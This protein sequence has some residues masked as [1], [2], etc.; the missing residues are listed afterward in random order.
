MN[1]FS[2]SSKKEPMHMRL[3][4][5][6]WYLAKKIKGRM[7]GFSLDAS[8]HETTKAAINAGRLLEQ[9]EKGED[10]AK[11]K[12]K[13]SK[14]VPKYW[15]EFENRIQKWRTD[16]IRVRNEAII[17]VHLLPWFGNIRGE[18]IH[19]G[20]VLSYVNT[21][22][23]AG[24]TQSTL[25]KE[26]R[27]LK[28]LM[29]LVNPKWKLPE[30][31]YAHKGKTPSRAL[32][33]EEILKVQR[34]IKGQSKLFGIQYEQIYEIMA[35]TSMDIKDVVELKWDQIDLE[36]GWIRTSRGKTGNRLKIPVCKRLAEIFDSMKVRN[37]DGWLFR[38]VTPSQVSVA[39]KRAFCNAGLEKFSAKSLRHFFPSLLGNEG[40][41][42]T[43]IGS[44]LGHSKGSRSTEQYI[45]AY[46]SKLKEAV[47]ILDRAFDEADDKRDR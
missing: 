22:E 16:S 43:V 30:I 4:N 32:T 23:L 36:T 19:T 15:V 38:Q 24:A 2:S 28:D 33:I 45:H 35:F 3:R 8:E 14:F 6:R 11:Q 1:T 29:V 37:M 26:L 47:K 13:L 31:E 44:I 20:E 12:K 18:D 27:V 40:S 41:P 25:K 34:F 7:R 39:F 46:D 21:R 9:L 10:P 5:G 17:R 42:G